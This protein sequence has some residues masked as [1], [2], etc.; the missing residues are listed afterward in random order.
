MQCTITHYLLVQAAC[1]TC[2]QDVAVVLDIAMV[3]T[4]HLH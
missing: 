4:I 1:R 3:P 2:I